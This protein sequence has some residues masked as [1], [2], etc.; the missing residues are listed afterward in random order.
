M[1]Y[2]GD[3]L[4]ILPTLQENSIDSCV[5]DPPYAI[6]FM[7]VDFDKA[8]PG[9]NFWQAILRVLKP[10]A[11]L[12][13]MGGSRT[14]HRLTC[15]I[16]DAGFQIR[17]NLIWLYGSGFPKGLNIGKALDKK[18]GE[19]REVTGEIRS[20]GPETKSHED[21]YRFKN[22]YDITKP[23]SEL[24]KQW[25]GW[26]T[27]LKPCY[28]NVVTARK[29]L[30]GNYVENIMKWGVGGI[31]IDA[32]R[33]GDSGGGRYPGN[34]LHDG[35]DEVMEEFA[36][37]GES[38]SNADKRFYS[39]G[40]NEIYNTPF[41]SCESYGY[42]DEGSV[43]RFFYCAKASKAERN[44]G[45]EELP[46]IEINRKGSG[47]GPGAW[48][49]ESRA[50]FHPTVKPIALMRWLIRL[51]TPK[52]GMVLDPFAGSGSTGI[53]A[54]LEGMNSILIELN[55]DYVNIIEKRM[56]ANYE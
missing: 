9:I 45:C 53:A 3:C 27:N 42:K 16:E 7:G 54:K 55:P 6:N 13:A 43:A 31:N 25:D 1:I 15:A 51:V 56:L 35:S 10:G 52:G 12:L 40:K 24:A 2:T 22:I 38:K 19:D 21:D 33:V 46:Q 41:N 39:G 14:T 4:Q 18:L 29:P 17:D 5:T 48:I 37:F 50:N 26:N 28:E 8:I 23:E 11:Y 32:C 36:K 44:K 30:E 49:G 34:L 20:K 47:P